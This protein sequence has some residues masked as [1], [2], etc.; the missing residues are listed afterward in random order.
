MLGLPIHLGMSCWG[1]LRRYSGGYIPPRVIKGGGWE[2]LDMSQTANS[3]TLLESG[4]GGRAFWT[5]PSDGDQVKVST[6]TGKEKLPVMKWALISWWMHALLGTSKPSQQL[7]Y[8]FLCIVSAPQ[9]I[10]VTGCEIMV[11]LVPPSC[12]A[13]LEL[14]LQAYI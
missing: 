3:I 10:V 14:G 4:A 5:P 2:T 1:Q 9:D 11:H 6:E 8:K 12:T 13:N 7:Y